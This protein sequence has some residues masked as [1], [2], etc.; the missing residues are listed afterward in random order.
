MSNRLDDAARILASPLPR[1]QALRL[2]GGALAGYVLSTFGIRRAKAQN[3]PNTAT[4]KCGDHTCAKGQT[5]CNTGKTPFCVTQGRTCCGNTSCGNGQACCSTGSTPFCVTQ[6]RTCCGNTSCGNGQG[7]CH[8]GSTPFCAEQGKTCCGNTSCGTSQTCCTNV[9]CA[10][11]L[12][13]SNGRC[14]A[15]RS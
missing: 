2:A 4:A 15:S 6:G 3:A 11:H 5:C 8:T 14:T 12:I 9:C 7:C 10:E 1:R 13:C